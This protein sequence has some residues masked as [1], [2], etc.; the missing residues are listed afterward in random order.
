MTITIQAIAFP[1]MIRFLRLRSGRGLWCCTSA[2]LCRRSAIMGASP[3]TFRGVDG[4]RIAAA[5][6]F[7]RSLAIIAPTRAPQ[8]PSVVR[9]RRIA[10]AFDG[11][12]RSKQ[13]REGNLLPCRDA[14]SVQL[15]CREPDRRFCSAIFDYAWQRRFT[16]NPLTRS[17]DT[18]RFRTNR[19]I[20]SHNSR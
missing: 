4:S 11:Q 2:R 12:S 15:K 20:A 3:E 10:L 13:R 6:V 9:L 8:S 7:F 5:S 16:R 19:N 18:K 17:I 1:M 14:A